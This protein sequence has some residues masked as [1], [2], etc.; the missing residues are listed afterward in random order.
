MVKFND[1]KQW[2]N[3]VVKPNIWLNSVPKHNG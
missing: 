2:L 1:L 3:I